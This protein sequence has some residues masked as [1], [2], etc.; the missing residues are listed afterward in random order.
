MRGYHI[1]IGNYGSGKTELSIHFAKEAIK[2]NLKVLFIDLDIVNPYFRSG[3]QKEML[4][5]LGIEVI[6]PP[7][8]CSN[9]DMP[10]VPASVASAFSGKYDTVI[11]DVGGDNVG[12]AALGQYLP[13][14]EK[15]KS[16]LYLYNVV[17]TKRPL[18]STPERIETLLYQMESA[19]R[20]KINGLIQNSNLSVETTLDTLINGAKILHTVSVNTGIPILY[21]TAT[22]DIIEEFKRQNLPIEMTGKCI[23]ITPCMRPSWLD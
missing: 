21:T 20:L 19:C 1:F 18:S 7:Y 5:K 12:S 10:V 8:A 14:F 4:E 9:V 6:L 16:P 13:Y 22:K 15:V 17:N 23:A 2:Q 11:F 3:E